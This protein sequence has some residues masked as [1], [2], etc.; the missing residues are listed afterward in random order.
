M[1]SALNSKYE[2][3]VDKV[4]CFCARPYVAF[5]ALVVYK[6]FFDLLY[7]LRIAGE[8]TGYFYT[9]N[10]INVVAGWIMLLIVAGFIS[11][12]YEQESASSLILTLLTVIYFVPMLVVCGYG[13]GP[14]SFL[15]F[16]IIYWAIIMVLQLKTPIYVL[17]VQHEADSRFSRIIWIILLLFV[18]AISLYFWAKYSHFHLQK[19][20]YNVYE[21]RA[22]AASYSVPGLLLYLRK[23]AV[24]LT[25]ILLVKA[26]ADRKWIILVYLCF[27]I[28]VSFSFAADKSVALFP[29]LLIGG[30]LFYRKGMIS[31]IVP[32]FIGLEALSFVTDVIGI[33]WLTS[34]IFT[35][36]GATLPLLSIYTYKFFE[37][38]PDDLFR[39]GVMGKMGFQ[40]IYQFLPNTIGNNYVEQTINCNNGM[41]S[42]VWSSFGYIGLLLMPVILIVCLRLMDAAVYKLDSRLIIGLVLYFAICFANAQW[43][44][45]LLTQ[46]YLITVIVLFVFPR[47]DTRKGLPDENC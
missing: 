24:I 34:F 22:E 19:D 8:R 33:R 6:V 9:L 40:S 4:A 39:Q 16:G 12:L 18:S 42:D 44:T 23:G 25:A 32:G 41:L 14:S 10:T 1:I 43:S 2:W 46:G 27:I 7:C 28:W 15:C 47:K 38:H 20:L 11:L 29:V 31:L 35:R 13:G 30:Y 3:L 45:V 17:D 36:Q 37:A 26:L 5:I 21:L